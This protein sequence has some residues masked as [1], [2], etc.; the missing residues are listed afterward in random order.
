M[1]VHPI[2]LNSDNYGYIVVE[3]TT[4]TGAFVDV[5][6]QPDK[7][8]REWEANFS[9]YTLASVFT[10]HK[11]W[12]HAGGNHI[13]ASRVPHIK[14]F[15]GTVDNVE[16]CTHPV[17]DGDLIQ[18]TPSISVKCIHTP[19]HTMGHICYYFTD[20]SSK[21][22]F[23]GDTLFI[24][25]AGKFFEGTG[26]DMYPSLYEKLAQLPRETLVYCGHEYTLSNYRFAL[27][28]DPDNERLRK[29]NMRAQALQADG[30]GTVPSTIQEELDTNPF[31][32]VHEPAIRDL[33]PGVD[34]PHELLTALRDKKDKFH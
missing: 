4:K 27:S 12:D 29:A 13:I 24:G 28:V 21:V 15:G 10:T 9:D 32:R 19:G 1:E 2:S 3:E 34:H 5:S 18:F 6:G 31:L 26:T 8:L 16:A 33:F 30:K 25:G 23:T 14:I 20:G 22:V 17:Q 7:M 11:H